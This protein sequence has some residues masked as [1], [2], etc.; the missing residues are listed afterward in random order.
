MPKELSLKMLVR[1]V[2]AEVLE[3]PRW[4]PMIAPK[5]AAM[6]RTKLRKDE[7]YLRSHM[8]SVIL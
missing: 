2:A 1:K 5:V 4:Y 8:G 3:G 7:D 6:W